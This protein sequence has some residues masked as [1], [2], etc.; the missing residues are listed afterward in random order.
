[1]PL[2]SQTILNFVHFIYPPSLLDPSILNNLNEQPK[3]PPFNYIL[4]EEGWIHLNIY[5]RILLNVIL[6]LDRV[7]IKSAVFS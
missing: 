3:P 2:L 4:L 5:M 7:K 1:M 6:S